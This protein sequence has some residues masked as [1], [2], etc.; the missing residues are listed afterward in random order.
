MMWLDQLVTCR[1]LPYNLVGEYLFD[2]VSEE[3]IIF[4]ELKDK[5]PL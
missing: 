1:G 5:S 2:A 3:K 4:V